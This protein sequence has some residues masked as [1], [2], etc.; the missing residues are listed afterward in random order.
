MLTDTTTRLDLGELGGLQWAAVV[1]AVTTGVLHLYA[2]AIDGRLPLVVAG[3]GFLGGVGLF[4][5]GYRNRRLY[6]VALAYTG[7]QV[8]AWAV[9]NAGTYST[10]GYADKAIQLLLIVVLAV[11]ARRG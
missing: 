1:L 11:L 7:I 4:L 5:A 9:V 3:L 6:L 10:L 8:V 2:G